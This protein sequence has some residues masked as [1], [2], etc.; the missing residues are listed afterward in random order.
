MHRTYFHN[1]ASDDLHIFKH[2]EDTLLDKEGNNDQPPLRIFYDKESLEA[3]CDLVSGKYDSTF[4]EEFTRLNDRNQ[5]NM[6]KQYYLSVHYYLPLLQADSEVASLLYAVRQDSQGRLAE[7][8][9]SKE[10]SRTSSLHESFGDE[11]LV[12]DRK[13]IS[14]KTN[15]KS[16]LPRRQERHQL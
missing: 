1:I 5:E 10:C 11:R 16:R 3:Y 7:V 9:E 12:R 15:T 2:I 14:R 8:L 6:L 4:G 13:L